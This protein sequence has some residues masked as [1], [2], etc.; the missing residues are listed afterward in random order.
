MKFVYIIIFSL[1]TSVVFCSN[2]NKSDTTKSIKI[3]S[4]TILGN[5]TTEDYIILRELDFKKNE[6]VSN[7]QLNYN[8][9]RVYSLGIFNKVKFEIQDSL[10][11][12][13]LIIRVEESWYIYPLPYLQLRENSFRRSSYGMSILYKNFRGRNE[14]LWGLATFGYDPTYMMYYYN[15]V[16]ITGQKLTFGLRLG[17]TDLQNRNIASENLNGDVFSYNY[18]YGS[19]S[20]GYRFNQFNILTQTTTFEYIDMPE[21]VAELSAS[22]TDKDRIY[23]IGILYEFD[24]RNL[25]QF[26]NDGFYGMIDITHK[27]F[28]LKNASYNVFNLDLRKYNIIYGDLAGKWRGLFRST[29][30]SKIPFYALSLLGDVEYIR[31]HRFD[32]R[33]GNNYIVTSFELSYPIIKEWNLSLDLPLLPKNLTS[34]RIGLYTNIF[35]DAG[36]TFNNGETPDIRS[37]DSGW[38]IGLTLLILPY[39]AFRFEYA[40]NEMNEGEF[41]LETGFSF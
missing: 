29:F 41:I 36:E 23:S 5:E 3:E 1:I 16:M 8:Q 30:G 22:G 19:L 4:I 9:E 37:F 39:N 2:I 27:G 10:G 17:Y 6:M 11:K 33:E 7:F 24:D 20:F 40:F 21:T 18:I 28:G 34:A 15:P 14:T 26:S 32:K 31:G 12:Y 38:G 35:V 25:K 13:N